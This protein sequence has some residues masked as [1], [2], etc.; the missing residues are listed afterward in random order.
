MPIYGTGWMARG[1]NGQNP[2]NQCPQQG[3]FAQNQNQFQ[4]QP[5]QYQAGGPQQFEQ[6]HTQ[7]FNNGYNAGPQQETGFYGQ[8]AGIDQPKPAHYG[9]GGNYEMYNPPQG[10]PPSHIN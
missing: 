8:E 5:Q 10:P 7:P 1:G 3:G 6:Q 4:N 9:Q 2:Q